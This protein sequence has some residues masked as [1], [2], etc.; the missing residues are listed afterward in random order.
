M[1]EGIKE[2][3]ESAASPFRDLG[4]DSGESVDWPIFGAKAAAKVSE[5]P[6]NHRAVIICG[7]GIGMSIVSNKFKG[8]RAALCKSEYEAE[9]S[10]KHNNA[11]VLNMGSRD[12]QLSDALKIL[13]TWM[14]TGFEGGR[15]QRRLDILSEIENENFK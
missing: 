3:L 5:D 7:S 13:R 9:M 10:R 15:H 14:S 2:Y 6:L 8:V 12:L 1:K 11:N 4:T